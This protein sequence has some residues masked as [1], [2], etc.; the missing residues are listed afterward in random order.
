MRSSSAS[1]DPDAEQARRRANTTHS[2]PAQP[3][4]GDSTA[5][6]LVE[7]PLTHRDPLDSHDFP[8]GGGSGGA[9]AFR[10]SRMKAP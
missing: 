4:H 8:D 1:P 9:E 5:S 7:M 3:D 10:R 2:P 6:T